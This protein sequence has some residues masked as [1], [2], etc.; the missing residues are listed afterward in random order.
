RIG[1]DLHDGTGQ[2]LTGLAMMA[3]RLAGELGGKQLPES[4]T[5]AKIVDG[6]EEALSHVRALAKG[7]VPVE[8]DAEG[9]MIAL[10]ELASR[11]SDLHG[12]NCTFECDEPVCILDNQ[13]AMHLWRLSQEAV[14]NDVKHGRRR[15]IRISL[16]HDGPIV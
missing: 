2:E 13:T 6:L 1:Q 8:V 10:S 12:V 15:N 3:V 7:L 9:L 14:N 16:G 11:T 5:A 4:K